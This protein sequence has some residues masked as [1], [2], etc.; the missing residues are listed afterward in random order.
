MAPPLDLTAQGTGW[1]IVVTRVVTRTFS[2]VSDRRRPRQ[3]PCRA[4]DRGILDSGTLSCHPPRAPSSH[5]RQPTGLETIPLL[6]NDRY[7]G[8]SKQNSLRG[9][10]GAAG[11]P[12][13][14]LQNSHPPFPGPP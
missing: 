3:P 9:T 1:Q 11:R 14:H 7:V 6:F 10:R 8:C 4:L 13:V 12:S 5:P 2:R